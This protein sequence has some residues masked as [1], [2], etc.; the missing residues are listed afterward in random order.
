[1]CGIA[2]FTSLNPHTEPKTSVTSLF[3]QLYMLSQMR[4]LDSSGLAVFW[5]QAGKAKKSHTRRGWLVAKELTSPVN[6]FKYIKNG[7]AL[8]YLNDKTVK[9]KYDEPFV[10]AAIGHCRAATKGAIT[11]AN[12]HPFSFGN[13]RFIGVHNG[14]IYNA[15]AVYKQLKDLDPLP[16]TTEPPVDYGDD[17][18]DRTDSEIVLYCIYRWGIAAVHTKIV[19]AWAF[20]WWD[21]NTNCL[22]FIR[23]NQR[24]L[25]YAWSPV[26]D[27]LF[28]VSEH[29]MLAFAMARCGYK[30]E[31]EDRKFEEFDAGYLYTIDVSS[32]T[33]VLNKDAKFPWTSR[34]FV[35]VSSYSYTSTNTYP[36]YSH[37]DWF[38]YN[39]EEEA[40][41]VINK[42][43]PTPTKIPITS[44]AVIIPPIKPYLSRNNEPIDNVITLK[45]SH[46]QHKV[47]SIHE[48]QAEQAA[49]YR[50]D[51]G[52]ADEPEHDHDASTQCVWC[53]AAL[54][55]DRLVGSLPIHTVGIV[56]GECAYDMTIVQ[57]VCDFYLEATQDNAWINRY[58]SLTDEAKG[59]KREKV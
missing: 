56:C 55:S 11:A 13:N 30:T 7:L 1:M 34:T 49:L 27:A 32:Y 44:T 40:T 23:N 26:D 3:L 38:G 48:W 16:N 47:I 46:I 19:G 43:N 58:L 50:S 53:G 6:M 25:F 41:S 39:E 45:Y 2:G 31:L 17:K 12:A 18:C 8:R 54:S 4:G 37:G 9:G 36:Q 15:E 35:P 29:S 52:P 21:Q 20:V 51:D 28:W 59:S 42:T 5:R 22:N 10:T 57:E 14:T 24:P 33:N